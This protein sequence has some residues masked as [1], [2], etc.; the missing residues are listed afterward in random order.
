MTVPAELTV[1]IMGALPGIERAAIP[2]AL[3]GL[4]LSLGQALFWSLLGNVVPVFAVYGLGD[5]WIRFTERRRGPLHRLTD[6]VFGITRHK[7]HD[8][9]S[10]YGLIALPVFVALPLPVTGPLSGALAAFLF[11]VPFKKAFPLIFIGC[12]VAALI[13]TVATT[14]GVAIFS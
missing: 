13:I 5:L 10:R 6:K 4:H 14:G 1:F 7:L 9:F 3:L 12:V 11:G 2:T 8:H